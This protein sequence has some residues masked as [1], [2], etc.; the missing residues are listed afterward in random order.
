MV[1]L[2]IV[3][4]IWGFF[5]Y[6]RQKTVAKLKYPPGV[7]VVAD[8]YRAK[9]ARPGANESDRHILRYDLL[10]NPPK[11][12]EYRR[13]IFSPLFVDKET[14]LARQAAAAAAAAAA[15]AARMAR[16]MA[17]VKPAKPPPMP[18]GIQNELAA[19]KF[20]GYLQKDGRKIVFLAKGREITPVKQGAT[21]LGRYVAT[22]ITE[23]VLILR[24]TGTG[25]E[26]IIALIENEPLRAA[27]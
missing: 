4:A 25:E 17:S 10:E 15:E 27:R 20:H 21:F 23:Q 19:F 5:S 8:S 14:M 2:L 22:S 24:V 7:R 9:A 13:D 6:P 1:L 26:V 11:S 12:P 16:K 3:S 18:S